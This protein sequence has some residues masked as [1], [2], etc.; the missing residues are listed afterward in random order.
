MASERVSQTSNP[1]R[2][3]PV[4]SAQVGRLLAS[5]PIAAEARAREILSAQPENAD[6]LLVLAAAL[7]RQGKGG[8]AKAILEPIVA[9]QPDQAFAQ[10]ELALSL[11]LLGDHPAA[12]AALARAVDFAPTYLAGWCALGDELA[13][14]QADAGTNASRAE[15]G[16]AFR[17][18]DSAIARKNLAE[19]EALLARAVDSSPDSGIARLRY[20]VVLLAGEKAHLA[21]PVIEELIHLDPDNVFYQELKASALQEFGDFHQAIAQYEDLLGNGPMRP[22]ALISY[23]RA[24][25]AIGREDES[26]AAFRK[27]VEILPTFAQGWRTLATVKTIRFAPQ[28]IDHLKSLL[29]RRGLLISTRVQLHFALAKALEDAGSWGEAFENYTRSQELQRTGVSGSAEKFH[30]FVRQLT[31]VFTPEFFRARRG[32]GSGSG[33][34]GPI[35]VVGMPRA[36]STLVQEILAAHSAIERTGELHDLGLIVNQLRGESGRNGAPPFPAF[37]ATLS[38]E[39]LQAIGSAYLERTRPRRKH[40]KHFFVDK[41]PENFIYAGLIHLI[42]PQAKIIDA[43]RHPL[44]CCFSIFR[45]YFPSAPPW[46][47]DLEEIGRFYAAYVELMAHWDE[48]LPSRVHRVIY[49]E[50]VANPEREV[51]RL[52]DYTGLPFEEACLRFYEQEQA[53]LTT[54][55][56]QARRPIY[57]SGLG[58]SRAYEPWLGPLKSALGSILAAYP[59]VPKFYP[60]LQA[61]VTMRLA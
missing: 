5:N 42:L 51:C 37:L 17:A 9:S 7:R 24:L 30:A 11:S 56:E 36:G 49:E 33:E 1:P 32:A 43:R 59:A 57:A 10:L 12:L 8:E 48:V 6:A 60:R 3:A 58:N 26:I 2:P 14:L 19:A 44:D 45:N 46:S 4:S 27:A 52:L 40:G 15:A 39:R 38:P 47:H 53:I 54:S 34:G 23:G 20:A 31:T 25:R 18:A 28:T 35:F 21:L 55:V 13:L 41:H 16:T 50:L 29:A 61:S 22:G